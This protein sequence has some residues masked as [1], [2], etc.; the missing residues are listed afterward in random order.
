MTLRQPFMLAVV[1]ILPATDR[2]QEPAIHVQGLEK[3]YKE[4]RVL[5]GVDFE[6]ARGK[7]AELDDPQVVRLYRILS[8]ILETGASDDR[9]LREAADI[10]AAGLEQAYAAGEIIAGEMA[11]DDL[12]LTCWTHL[13]SSPTRGRSGCWT[14][15][16]S[17]AGTV[18]PG[19]SGWQSRPA[20]LRAL[21]A[22]HRFLRTVQ[23]RDIMSHRR[24]I[25]RISTLIPLIGT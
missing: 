6:V 22:T 4:L 24:P 2:V 12:T 19:Q 15:C 14:S 8:E 1:S 18:G 5:R 21:W 17:V 9:R 25:Y 3:S 11:D 20:N 7:L 16:A 10:M 23:P 13:P